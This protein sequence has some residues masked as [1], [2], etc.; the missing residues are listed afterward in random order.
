MVDTEQTRDEREIEARQASLHE[1]F[2]EK[3]PGT[4]VGEGLQPLMGIGPNSEPAVVGARLEP[5]HHCFL[6]DQVLGPDTLVV[7]VAMADDPD[8]AV[9]FHAAEEETAKVYGEVMDSGLLV[10]CESRI[11]PNEGR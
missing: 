11:E 4:G 6:D 2:D 7:R 10:E 9:Y 1:A 8:G 3:H 5:A